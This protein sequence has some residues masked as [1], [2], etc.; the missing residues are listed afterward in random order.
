[1][2]IGDVGAGLGA[3]VGGVETRAVG[4]LVTGGATGRKGTGVGIGVSA[5][6]VVD[7]DPGDA[8]AGTVLVGS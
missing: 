1:M 2:R 3:A 6:A 5:G 7:A 4:M 8:G